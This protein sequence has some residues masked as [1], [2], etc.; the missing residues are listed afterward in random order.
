MNTLQQALSDGKQQ[1]ENQGIKDAALDAWLLL[2]YVCKINRSYYYVHM[3][4]WMT[5][6]NQKEYDQLIRQR[7]SH[8][9]LQQLTHQTWFM[10]IPFYVNEHVLV[11]RQD[12]E[13]LVEE[14]LKRTQRAK[15]I[16]DM[17]TG[18]GC[19][20]LSIL[21][22]CNQKKQKITGIGADISEEALTVARRNATDLQLDAEFVKS[23][24]F[25]EITGTYD[26]IVSNP[27]YIPT[28]NLAELMEEV[29]EH[30]PEIALDGKEDGLHFYRRIV[31]DAASFLRTGGWLC[32][33]IGYD[34]GESVKGLLNQAGY[35]NIQI[36]NDL[37][38][39]HRVVLGQWK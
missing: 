17:C 39:L 9:P 6:E 19:I 1:L 23:D 38:G 29:K 4:E 7:G 31:L 8:I 27:P 21:H 25:L 36:V 35:S 34:Q 13:C 16:L 11:P 5:E 22:M 24:L 28:R 12:T 10:G 15:R 30:E 14:V 2:E 26:I 32:L 37:S 18:S 3:E 20:L 33:E